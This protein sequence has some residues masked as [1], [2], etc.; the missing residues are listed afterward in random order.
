MTT[1][2]NSAAFDAKVRQACQRAVIAGTEM[3]IAEGSRLLASPP[4]T[5]RIYERDNPRRIHQASAP[6]EAPATDLGFLIASSEAR[7]PA[8]PNPN[9]IRGVANWAADYAADLE[10]GTMKI[11]PRPY[12]RPALDTVSPEFLA[13]MRAEVAGVT[14]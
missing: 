10:L 14:L 3:V 5:G 4:K 11:A 12:A 9:L 2:W 7:Y 6:G 8:D 13:A 1:T